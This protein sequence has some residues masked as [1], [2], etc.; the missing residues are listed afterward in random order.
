V[1][2]LEHSL[3][4]VIT[5][6]MSTARRH[7][8][9][10]NHATEFDSLLRSAELRKAEPADLNSRVVPIQMVDSTYPCEQAGNSSGAFVMCT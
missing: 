7:S 8:A 4:V 3:T 1:S 5:N 6:S 9:A 10:A 2:F